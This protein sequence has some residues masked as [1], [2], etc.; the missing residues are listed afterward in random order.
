M[1]VAI[2]QNNFRARAQLH[3]ER[4]DQGKSEDS[5]IH[6]GVELDGARGTLALKQYSQA[7]S[8]AQDTYKR[9][10]AQL[11][12]RPLDRDQDLP[13]A[14]G[15]AIEVQAMVLVAEVATHRS[16]RFYLGDKKQ[17][18]QYSSNNF[19]QRAHPE[20]TSIC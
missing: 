20:K 2:G 17:L 19:D 5:A 1:R 6:S 12:K 13:L 14:L 16:D 4:A 10:Q 9:V 3:P 8:Y 11:K 18:K 15:A 7:E